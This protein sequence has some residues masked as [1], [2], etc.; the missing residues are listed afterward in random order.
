MRGPD[1]IEAHLV[2]LSTFE[3]LKLPATGPMD[4]AT[5]KLYERCSTPIL[6]L[7]PCDLMA[8]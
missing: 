2:F 4:H 5:T 6:Y 8:D 1:D 3:E 7:G